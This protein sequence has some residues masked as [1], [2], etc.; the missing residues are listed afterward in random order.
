MNFICGQT[1]RMSLNAAERN[2]NALY[3][4]SQF[5]KKFLLPIQPKMY[6]N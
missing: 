2:T 3:K 5:K 4:K 6:N 1:T